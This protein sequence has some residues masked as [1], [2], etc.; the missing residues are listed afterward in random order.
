MVVS[1]DFKLG[2]SRWLI[3]SVCLAMMAIV[4]SLAVLNHKLQTTSDCEVRA[5]SYSSF[6]AEWGPGPALKSEFE[7]QSQCK[8]TWIQG[9]DAGLLIEK[10]KALDVDVVVGLDAWTLRPSQSQDLW[11]EHGVSLTM[12]SPEFAAFS[13]EK[14]LALDWAPVGFVYHRSERKVPPKSLDELLEQQ[15]SGSLSLLAPRASVPGFLFFLW[16]LA[17][18]GPDKGLEFLRQLAP[19]VQSL[20]ASWSQAYGQFTR[21]LVP[22]VLSYGTSPLYH[23]IIEN[24]DDVQF[25]ADKVAQPIH[26]EFATIRKESR[27]PVKARELL[28]FLI[29][30]N[31]QRTLMSKNWMF[32]VAPGGS[33][34]EGEKD[35]VRKVFQAAEKEFSPIRK[36]SLELTQRML[37]IDSLAVDRF[38]ESYERQGQ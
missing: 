9:E 10:G 13:G 5:I 27:N 26:I 11:L 24:R 34:F 20:S 6:L 29:S 3:G 12:L 23:Q 36:A 30:D 37:A 28:L 25:A 15:Y 31:G 18:R 1:S 7:K 2:R 33:F 38:I 17:D 16:I 35:P 22:F 4:V 19:Q 8:L 14:V 21:G 32:S